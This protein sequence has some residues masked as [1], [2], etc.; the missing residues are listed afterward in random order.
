[1]LGSIPIDLETRIGGDTGEPIV[2]AH[3]ASPQADAFRRV[4]AGVRNRLS[5][6]AAPKLPLIR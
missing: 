2:V 5:E 4:A 3:P 6:A 1:M